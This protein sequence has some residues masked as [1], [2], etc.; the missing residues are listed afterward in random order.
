MK[1]RGEY[2]CREGPYIYLY[3]LRVLAG[4][5]GLTT[6]EIISNNRGFDSSNDCN[7]NNYNKLLSNFRLN[8]KLSEK[9]PALSMNSKFW[10]R[11]CHK[12]GQQ[13]LG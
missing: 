12:A 1:A 10:L 4:S 5:K 7:C 3:I 11:H 13:I 8:F 2:G 9:S 6:R